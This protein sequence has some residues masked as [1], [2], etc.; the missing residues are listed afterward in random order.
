MEASPAGEVPCAFDDAVS[1]GYEAVPAVDQAVGVAG[2]EG[3][4]VADVERRVAVAFQD[5]VFVGDVGDLDAGHRLDGGGELAVY[6]AQM[7]HTDVGYR[8]AG[9]GRADHARHKLGGEL[10]LGHEFEHGVHEGVGTSLDLGDAGNLR[11]ELIR[12]GLAA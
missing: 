1:D 12:E 4:S 9:A 2:Y 3:D 6:H 7:A 5:E 10:E 8:N 11:G